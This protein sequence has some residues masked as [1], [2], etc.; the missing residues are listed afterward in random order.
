MENT[1]TTNDF[2][3]RREIF[4]KPFKGNEILSSR[5][6]EIAAGLMKKEFGINIYDHS[7]IPIVFT[8]GWKEILMT[9]GAEQREECR[10]D[11]CGVSVEYTTEYSDSD[12]STNIVP[13]MYH[14]KTPLFQNND[15]QQL[16]LGVS[17]HDKLLEAYTSWRSV[18]ALE[19]LTGIENKVFDTILNQYGINVMVSA[20]IYPILG[21][22][23]AA[24]VQLARELKETINMYN[25]FEIDIVEDK[26][27]LTPLAF[28]KQFLKDDSK[29]F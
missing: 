20:A 22:T 6:P 5:I 11:V 24:G 15:T 29:K 10:C 1:Q 3:Q 26:V 16:T 28:V 13:Q 19:A 8:T 25:I 23:Y 21:A 18:Y 27:V 9:M 4:M 2:V 12:K 7:H 17:Y 14:T